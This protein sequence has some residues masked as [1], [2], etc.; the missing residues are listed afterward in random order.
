MG[1]SA[2]SHHRRRSSMLAGTGRA[3]QPVSTERRDDSLWSH[4]D[5]GN[6]KREEQ[7]PLTAEE[8]TDASDP[9]S[10]AESLELDLMSSDDDQYDEET[11]LTSNQKRQ[12]RRRRNQRRKLDA[13]IADT[14]SRGDIDT[15]RSI[16]KRLGVNAAL[17]LM[18]YFFS[19]SISIYNKWMF[20]ESDVVFPFPLFTTSLHMLVQF[21]LSVIILWI[22]PSLRPQHPSGSAATS[23]VDGPE[24]KQPILTKFFYFTRLVPCGTA[25]SLDIGL[26][27]MSLKFISLTFL[28]MCKSSALAFVLLFAILFRLESPS[29]KLILIIATMT[30]GVVMM[31]AGETAFNALG[32]ALV[33]ASAFF[34]GFR[35]GL[36]QILLLRHPATSNPFATLFLLTPVMFFSLIVIA[37]SV[38]GPAEIYQG[39]LVLAEKRGQL[40]GSFLLIFPGVLA[41][42]MISSE[43]ALLKRSSV[44]TLS[45]CGIFKEVVTISAAGIIFHDKLTAVNLTGL[46]VTISSIAAYNYMKISKMRS[47]AQEAEWS[48]ESSPLSDTEDGDHSSGGERQQQGDY[49]RVAIQDAIIVSPAPGGHLNDDQTASLTGDQQRSFRVRASGSRHTRHALSISTSTIP[50][51]DGP[52]SPLRSAPPTITTMAQAGFPHLLPSNR[53]GSPDVQSTSSLSPVRH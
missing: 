10:A 47:E 20:S 30:I 7:E 15:D 19:L 41:F 13:R 3:S 33:I 45:I 6:H 9:S 25:T 52:P 11:G 48:R 38:E 50:E 49:R 39:Y 44:V 21:T 16:V 5:G 28:T 18:W 36:T 34:S 35:W 53:E 43:F 4:A 51:D 46:F 8:D 40:L 24:E 27:N 31:V 37:L 12:R 2:G 32:F 42:C 14:K 29:V 17:I 22:F 26:G 23:P 1:L